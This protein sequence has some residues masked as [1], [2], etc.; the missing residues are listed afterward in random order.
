MGSTYELGHWHSPYYFSA[1]EMLHQEADGPGHR[2][3]VRVRSEYLHDVD[4]LLRS[5]VDRSPQHSVLVYVDIQGTP[6]T[7]RIIGP[8]TVA[9][10]W[11]HHAK[12]GLISSWLYSVVGEPKPSRWD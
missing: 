5:L 4:Y 10:F 3:R 11:T 12:R 6:E 1:W 7:F 9:E 8:M 2:S